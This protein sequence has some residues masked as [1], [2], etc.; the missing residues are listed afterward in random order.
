L[1]LT[2]ELERSIAGLVERH[3]HE[4]P[5]AV[6]IEDGEREITYAEL[7]FAGSRI[8]AALR[9]SGVEDEEP[10][11]VCLPRSW[12][13]VCA[14]LGALRA[15]AAYVPVDPGYPAKRQRQLLETARVRTVLTGPAHETGLPAGLRRLDP[16]ALALAGS[17]MVDPGVPTGI[18]RLA[19][20]LF[21]SGST[22]RPK[23]VEV[24]QRNLVHVLRSGSDIVARPD[25]VVLHAVPLG[26]DLSAQEIWGALLNGA[27]LVVAPRGR[28]DPAELGR[29]IAT[30]GVTLLNISTGLFHELVRDGLPDLGGLRLITAGGDILSPDA[31]A[32]LRKA[33]PGVRLL[34][35]YGPT[36]A[37]IV[38]STFE[39]SDVDGAPIPIGRPF[40]GYRLDVRD[41]SGALL[42]DNEVGELWIGGPGVARGYCGD[43]ERT[44]A[45]FPLD[46]SGEGRLYKTGDRVQWRDDGELL[47]LGRL[48][49]Q[50]KIDGQRV[51]PGEVEHVLASHPDLRE[52]AVEAREDVPGYKRLVGYAV[53]REGA[54]ANPEDLGAYL[55]ERLPAFMV[56]AT[57]A[58][59]DALPLNERGKVDRAALPDPRGRHRE[60][61]EAGDSPSDPIAE[62]MAEIL[63][64][65]SVGPE[66][67]F[68]ELG[69][70][71]L[72]AIQLAGRL[73]SL[74]GANVDI[75]A[76]FEAPTPVSLAERIAAPDGLRPTLQPLLPGRPE[77]TAPL[78]AAQR[79]AWLFGRLH[80]DSIAYQFAAVFRLEGALDVE[81]LEAALADLV[82]RHEILRTSFEERDGE[83]VQVIHAA[84]APRLERID[85]RHSGRYAWCRLV[86]EHVRTRI[87]PAEAPLVRWTLARLGESSWRL[88]HVEHHLVH[89]GWSFAVLS[90]DLAELY[91]ARVE[92]RRLRLSQ[93][94]VQFQDY[95]RWERRAHR[96]EAVRQQIE[97]WKRSLDPDPPL[98]ELPGARPRPPR[99]SFAGGAVRRRV[100]AEL[101]SRL[102]SLGA[103]N[104]A[105]LYMVTL[106]AF[107][108]QLQRY[109]GRDEIQIGSGLA[110]RHDPNAERLIGMIVNTVGLRFD[111]GGNPTVAEL[112]E[113]V[114]AA[115]LEAY[116]NADAPFDAVVEAIRPP[117]DPSRS[118]LIQALFS[119]HDSPRSGQGWSGLDL[120]L[121]QGVPNGTAKADL[122]VVG[123]PEPDG[124]ITFIWEHSDLL[125]DAAADRLAGH[126][127]RLLEQFVERPDARL[128]ELDLQSEEEID[129]LADWRENP[130]PFDREATV[131][132]LVV[133]R[134]RRDPAAIAVSDEDCRLT[135]GELIERAAAVSGALG[136]RGV[137]AGNRVGVLLERSADS[138][139]AQLGILSA[140]GAYVP[141]D[142]QHPPAR[143]ARVLADAGAA[144]VLT[145]AELRQRL[146]VGVAALEI[147]EAAAGDPAEPVAVGPDDLAYLV[148]TSGSTG[149]PKGV[150]VTHGNVVRLV[151]GPAYAELGPG[152]AML[153][154]ASPAFDASTLE[155]W[156]PLA[157]G[158]RIVC[159]TEQP[160]PDA[161]AAAISAHGVTTLFLTTGLFHELVDRRP[162]CLGRL[163]QLL[164][165][166]D[167]LSP[168][169]MRRAL[170]ALPPGARLTA[171]YGP[172]ETTTFATTH[173]LSPGDPVE[174]PIPIGRPIQATSC[175]VIDTGGREV[176]IGV[177]GELAVGGDGVSRG[178]RGD[179]ELT[180]A[181][182]HPDPVR[183]GGRRYL[184]GDRARWRPDGVLEFLGRA[185]RQLKVRGVRVE[186]AEIEEALRS[187]PAVTD[188]AVLP[189]ERAPGDLA[190][191][192]YFVAPPGAAQPSAEA[193][194]AYALARLPTAMVPTAWVGLEKLPLTA[195]GKLDRKRLPAPD[196]EHL[197]AASG[198]DRPSSELER[199][200]VACFEE[201][202]GMEQVGVED[203]FFALGGHSLLAVSLF[204]EL[205][206]A[207]GRR[208]PLATIFEAPTPRQLA[209]RLAPG[210]PAPR[211]D[212]LVALKP[213]GD[214]PPLFVV[215]AGDGNIVG[216]GPLARHMPADQPVYGLQPS[217]LD[218]HR[219]LDRGFEQ[220]AAR[221]V[222]ALRAVQPHGP[223][224]L[225]GRCSGAAIAYEMAQQLRTAGAEVPLLA[226]LDAAP[227]PA[228]PRE[229]EPGLPFEP[230]M[231]IAWVRARRAGEEV[232]D[233]D[234]ADAP[235]RLA[236]W[237]RSP[238]APG[239]SRYLHEVWCWRDD[240]RAVWPDPLGADADALSRFA[241]DHARE[242][243][244]TSLLLPVATRGCVA[245][246][247]HTWDGA[248][249]RAW[250]ELG[251]EPAA[252]L[253]AAGWRAFR[254]LLVEPLAGGAMNRYLLGAWE[255]RPDLREGYPSP[256]GAN[257][258][259]LRQWAWLHG[260]EE[261]GLAPY[262]LPPAPWPVPR[263]QRLG[264]RIGLTGNRARLLKS[265]L[266]HA[267]RELRA[268]GGARAVDMLER[269]LD[270]P[271]PGAYDRQG[272]RV[273][274]AARQARA[275]YR[276]EPWPGRVVLISSEEYED[277]HLHLAWEERALDGVERRRLPVSHLGM[278]REPGVDL[279]ARQLE[280]CIAEALAG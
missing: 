232:P 197:A 200:V 81:S 141:L 236:A 238:V 115:A 251:G 7:D 258:E 18:D 218:G 139:V 226:S 14:F 70:T 153:H 123:V 37:T 175:E 42:P 50:V 145:D 157:N 275:K 250:E 15:G 254:R 274:A 270:R 56:P 13:A 28:P 117:R 211:W 27:R 245:P 126:H 186:P 229:L 248:M 214:R 181:R 29:L 195:N 209:A 162:E 148:Y 119:F 111:L 144:A 272:R 213:G 264:I 112:L 23:G 210:A 240:L 59:L 53:P 21:T 280:D 96:S 106:A 256:L 92:A 169:H 63:R 171:C 25:D 160:S 55:G 97:H 205:E 178:Y 215:A 88:V 246:D 68:F 11:A 89:D 107:V 241:W 77:A 26:F 83:P 239:V 273:V 151:D 99:E 150:E 72:L 182:F 54:S 113:R 3:A 132:D 278:L 217:G 177:A 222:A 201:A 17:E 266:S 22:G 191:A 271:L 102:R 8:A 225:A 39:V 154:A 185:D 224:L 188:V 120:Q 159:L 247:G 76:V 134:A 133:A 257:A 146:P 216:F 66:E 183:P 2:T 244:F 58:M 166:G 279:L 184:T 10:V 118:P 142:P 46:P 5:G 98:I 174:G 212:N 51:E 90:G 259:A 180:A 192:A 95:A 267:A 202:L 34:N 41:E 65:D 235:A 31:A 269:R 35:S 199:R 40:P 82:D 242:E 220:M 130:A 237:L 233:M 173:D 198:G 30:R 140:G 16:G 121:L 234:A 33:H 152:A 105:T 62:L 127:L 268:E 67:S 149:E 252:P 101:V 187:H 138:A 249:S 170:A 255:G 265:R 94:F 4:R 79:R 147:T 108:V 47:F 125:D 1:G 45:A 9:A 60:K 161:V 110:N 156:G 38:A 114:R 277:R 57:I 196:R 155:I 163:R 164:A 230:L 128:S 116:A 263:R 243:I 43:P 49:D 221:Y 87:N 44:A 219:P 165:G 104:R 48:D 261:E 61:G 176:P 204:A 100:L 227:P 52:A 137:R 136:E 207:T 93:P 276:A 206:R 24:T 91:S 260:I 122:N 193:L 129:L 124:T 179:P 36:E 85:L 131:P 168:D 223:Y 69:G 74:L 32:R 172:T 78:S 253:S 203:D 194:R 158:G 167:V 208:L 73:R 86:R 109:A 20:I 19:Y 135:Y 143:M 71:S 189:F 231:E 75:G 228:G 190:L 80:P 6:A 12:Q 84:L 64:L 262:L 103:A